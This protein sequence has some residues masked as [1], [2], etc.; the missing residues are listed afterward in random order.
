MPP[1]PS[2]AAL[3]A[4]AHGQ[5]TISACGIFG[6]PAL[7]SKAAMT[8]PGPH[9]A[10]RQAAA[11]NLPQHRQIGHDIQESLGT[12]DDRRNV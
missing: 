11:D 9:T 6:V 3:P 10:N 5:D 8:A 1:G 2:P 12:S 7:A 4:G